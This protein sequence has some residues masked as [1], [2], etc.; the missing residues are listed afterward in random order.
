LRENK[1][2]FDTE[3]AARRIGI[4]EGFANGNHCTLAGSYR[5]APGGKKEG[6]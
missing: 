6:Q 3:K 1:T 4:A 5:G 2:N